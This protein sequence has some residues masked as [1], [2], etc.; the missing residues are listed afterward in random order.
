MIPNMQTN[1]QPGYSLSPVCT[2]LVRQWHPRSAAAVPDRSDP[3]DRPPQT[4]PPRPTHL[5]SRSPLSE[6]TCIVLG[7][8]P[9]QLHDRSTGC[10]AK[11]AKQAMPAPMVHASISVLGMADGVLLCVHGASLDGWSKGRD[12]W[13]GRG[14][15][16]CQG[17]GDSPDADQGGS[18][19]SEAALVRIVVKHPQCMQ[20]LRLIL[21]SRP[22]ARH[23]PVDAENLLIVHCVPFYNVARLPLRFCKPS[24]FHVLCD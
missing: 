14:L 24:G 23:Q 19:D 2:V 3:R 9:S 5:Q 20:H 4:E 18:G 22:R 17:G 11:A 10:G 1:Q 12:R 15:R 7:S 6:A 16:T 13:G 21:R 8:L